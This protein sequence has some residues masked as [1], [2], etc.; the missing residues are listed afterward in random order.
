MYLGF[1]PQ[2]WVL[3]PPILVRS[4]AVRNIFHAGFIPPQF[5]TFI[6]NTFNYHNLTFC[7]EQAKAFRPHDEEDDD[8]DDDYSDDEELQSPI[9]EVDPFVFFVDTVKGKWVFFLQSCFA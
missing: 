2:G 1:T 6:F 4:H 7:N 9:D 3:R 8:S 5:V